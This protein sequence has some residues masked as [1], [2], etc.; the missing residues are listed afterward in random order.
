[1]NNPSSTA[2]LLA[3]RAPVSAHLSDDQLSLLVTTLEIP[4]GA[5]HA[6]KKSW[7]INLA[8]G[9]ES[10]VSDKDPISE[11]FA[12]NDE[13]TAISSDKKLVVVIKGRGS[14]L[15]VTNPYRWT[16]PIR[17]FDA[18]SDLDDPP[19]LQLI[20]LSTHESRWLT[21]DG[22]RWSFVRWSPNADAVFACRSLD[23]LGRDGYQ[24]AYLIDL[25]GDIRALPIP[26]GRSIVGTWLAD[27]RLAVIVASPQGKPPGSEACLYIVDGDVARIID[28]P[29]L[30]GDVYGDQPAELADSYDNILLAHPDGSLI[31][32]T[33]SRGRM[34]VVRLHPDQPN[35][36]ESL[37]NDDRCCSPV[38]TTQ[39]ELIFTTQSSTSP[40]EI[41]VL[42]YT[43]KTQR[44]LTHFNQVD[45][46]P[47]VVNRFTIETPDGFTLDAWFL[48]AHKTTQPL[49]TVSIIH[50]GPHFA[51]GEAFSLDA[52]ALCAAG[53]GVLYTNV[54][55][56]TGYGDAFAYAAHSNWA[57]GPAGDQLL[58]IDQ[59]IKLGLADEKKLGIAG[60]S[61]GGY[62]SAW[63]A[64]TTS[65]F[66][67]AVIENPVTDLVSMYG[68][69][70]IGAT[71]FP[72]QFSGAPHEQIETYYRQSPIM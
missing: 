14:A 41:A 57:E 62:L 35:S 52:H 8:T 37:I 9:Q 61:Y 50:G 12:A 69:S 53:F 31:I 43:T 15:D 10:E 33:G 40:V 20:D 45:D 16:R 72:T 27:G 18:L 48:S 63:L 21:D 68:T 17:Y 3:N 22:W 28:V 26:G 38:A 29:D 39:S 25:E 60:N 4:I 70:D 66:Q 47:L 11:Q 5:Q 36:L 64:S 24:Y 30:F 67:A 46:S 71:F 7:S 55:G 58:V 59:A 54:R 32:R 42:E 51:Y 65:R 6:L 13:G 34:G 44:L 1:M 49:P 23:P 19:Q 2:R 56:S